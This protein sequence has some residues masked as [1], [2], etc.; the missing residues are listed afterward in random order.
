MP[1][2]ASPDLL[3][4]QWEQS[5]RMQTVVREFTELA[6][7]EIFEPL[8][9]LQG[10]QDVSEAYGVWLDRIGERM[11]LM[12]PRIVNSSP[13]R[14]GFHEGTGSTNV[15][16]DQLSF[17][18]D[19]PAFQPLPDAD[20]RKLIVARGTAL[21]TGDYAQSALAVD[22]QLTFGDVGELLIRVWSA[23][24]GLVQR[25]KLLGCLPHPVGVT[26]ERYNYSLSLSA[27][28]ALLPSPHTFVNVP[29]LTPAGVRT[30]PWRWL[31]NGTVHQCCTVDTV[32]F[33]QP[34][35]VA[36][37]DQMTITMPG[38]QLQPREN[39]VY[40]NWSLQIDDQTPIPFVGNISVVYNPPPADRSSLRITLGASNAAYVRA[41]L[42]GRHDMQ[43]HF[44]YSEA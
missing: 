7:N 25:A 44:I 10:L 13:N 40:N 17:T 41:R 42:T 24:I 1:L 34:G 21:S 22:S 39:T 31:L 27:Q 6:H 29:I 2:T 16:F 28:S 15:G 8:A 37:F 5:P 32:A 9:T 30:M 11:G 43:L 38:Y 3:P 14:F 4:S 23:D 26:L 36:P 33:R 20:Y 35:G 19:S 18:A 12:R